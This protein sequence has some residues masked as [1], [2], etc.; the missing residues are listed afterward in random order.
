MPLSRE[1]EPGSPRCLDITEH[2][3]AVAVAWVVVFFLLSWQRELCEL[4]LNYNFNFSNKREVQQNLQTLCGCS[5]QGLYVRR[6]RQVSASAGEPTQL[7]WSASVWTNQ[8]MAMGPLLYSCLKITSSSFV[9][10]LPS[11]HWFTGSK[12][13]RSLQ[14]SRCYSLKFFSP[15]DILTLWKH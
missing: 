6:H 4:Y 15:F 1:G 2:R 5:T 3:G 12:V 10:F 7:H 14:F 13:I 9:S 8:V 11:I